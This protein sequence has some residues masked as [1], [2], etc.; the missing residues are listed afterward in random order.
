MKA[1]LVTALLH[2]LSALPLRLAQGVGAGLG[3]LLGWLPGDMRRITRINLEH[4]LPDLPA[5]ERERLARASL[6][7]AGRAFAELGAMW[8]WRPERLLALVR[9]VRGWELLE[10]AMA[11]GRGIIVLSPH[12]GAWELGSLYGAPRHPLTALYRPL[13]VRALDDLVRTARERTGA[14]LMPT[15]GSGVR[16]LYKALERGEMVGI[17]PDQ[18]PGRGAGVFAPF[19]GHPAKTMVLVSR[20]ASRSGAA[21][22][23]CVPER[24]PRGRGFRLH[25]TPAPAEVSAADLNR[26]VAAMN[27]GVEAWVRRLPA[28]Y[29]WSYKRFKSRP[30]GEPRW[31]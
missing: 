2:L 11:A 30:E 6:V 19:F 3:R 9:E 21:V 29:L 15:D 27:A 16:A 7:E 31:Y 22:L 1:L 24:L 10:A 20:L 28:Q 4:C 12:L 25:F 26:S 23:I 5:R 13:R 8:L 14:R 18:D 17:L